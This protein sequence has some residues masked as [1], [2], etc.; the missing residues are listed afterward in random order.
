MKKSFLIF[1][2]AIL[3][4][5]SCLLSYAEV[6]KREIGNL[7][8]ENIPEIPQALKD[9]TTQYQN[10]RSAYIYDWS[11]SGDGILIGTRF[12]ETSQVHF[13]D[14]PGGA[15]KQ[16]TFFN[17]PVGGVDLN[18]SEGKTCFL[19]T[20]D[21]GGSEYYQVFSFDM[22]TSKYEMISDGK[23]RN[24]GIG[25]S[26][27]GD[28]F[29]FS[30][31]MRNG[32]DTDIYYAT[33]ENPRDYK[34]LVDRGGYWG[35]VDWSPDDKKLLVINYI[36]INESYYY[37]VDIETKEMTQINPSDKKIAYG[38]AL[39]AKNGKGIYITSDEGSE[40]MNLRYYSLKKRKF[41]N[42][43]K[44]IS[45]DI[46]DLDLS[47]SGRLLAFTANEDGISK[48]YIRDNKARQR[49]PVP[50]LPI[51]QIYGLNFSP[52]GKKLAMCFNTPQTPGDIYVLNI[53][54][55]ELVRWTY[56]EVGG[57]DTDNFVV[58]ELF[59]Y[60]TFDE[61]GGELRMI[62]AFI[63]KPKKAEKPFPVLISIHGGPEGQY[64]PNFSSMTQY[65][66]NEMGIAFIA[67]NVRGS[68]GY[69]KSYLLMDNGYKREESVYDIGALLD[70]I[71][72]QPDLD[73]DKIAVIGGS[74]GGY[75]VLS[76][77]THYNDRLRCAIDIVGISNFVTFLENT[78][79]YR[80]DLR[81]P[82]Y[83]DERD[84]EMRKF[85]IKISPTTNAHKI[86][87]PLLIV[88]GL[89]D[90]R[91]PASEAEQILKAIR[92]NG[93]EAWYLLAKD[94]G[95]GFRKKSNRDFYYYSV[96][97]FLERYLLK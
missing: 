10:V 78:K 74:Y 96:V 82:E 36:S 27:K 35:A 19:F 68:S 39:W 55:Q 6:E 1:T 69:G 8:I 92:D 95:H 75:M 11:P 47:K 18:P 97:M 32:R 58:P 16:I 70:W 3:I 81:R 63:F 50:E 9:R 17:E 80:Q 41:I 56:S 21:V 29:F 73:K 24:G 61:V 52:D 25:W 31:T 59:H 51:G 67:P 44:D 2:N 87:K 30:S 76:S 90:P 15:R 34:L 14:K 71:E 66:V 37:V 84:P 57:L 54:T 7:V 40:F 89:N 13:V 4:A 43:T 86:S 28:K 62:P 5:G 77:M 46:E 20:K 93:T 12:G 33:I 23:S 49:L 45:W 83:G 26:N 85:L 64:K 79:E 48:L 72:T 53:E 91:V 60:S 42:L 94:E 22:E 38:N 88:Q 65:Y